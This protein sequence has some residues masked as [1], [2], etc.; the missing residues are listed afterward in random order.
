LIKKQRRHEKGDEDYRIW[1]QVL[2]VIIKIEQIDQDKDGE[3]KELG[4]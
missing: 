2:S 3:V 1:N 4:V